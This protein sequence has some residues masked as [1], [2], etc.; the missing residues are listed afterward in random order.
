MKYTDWIKLWHNGLVKKIL[1]TGFF[2]VR[3]P[4]Y[5]FVNYDTKKEIITVPVWFKSNFWSIP[6]IL[7]MFFN[8]TKYIAY[9]L[10]DYLYSKEWAIYETKHTWYE[11]YYT[12]K[13][14]DQI[15]LATLHLEGAGFIERTLIY[16]WVRIWGWTS[17]KK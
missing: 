2:E 1:N 8:P 4:F 3:E 9:I 10:H 14:A 13:E 6:I 12:R 11:I 5:W 7:R 17:Y 15:L 16:L